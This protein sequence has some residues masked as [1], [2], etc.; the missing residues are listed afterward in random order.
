M[1]ETERITTNINKELKMKFTKI[2]EIEGR[3]L[4]YYLDKGLKAILKEH[5]DSLK[6][7]IEENKK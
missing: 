2:A 6:E 5:E 7:Y 3:K 1:A 4:N